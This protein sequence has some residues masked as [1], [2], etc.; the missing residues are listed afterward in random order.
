MLEKRQ[1]VL[2]EGAHL[3]LSKFAVMFLKSVLEVLK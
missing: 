3:R 2:Y 1:Y